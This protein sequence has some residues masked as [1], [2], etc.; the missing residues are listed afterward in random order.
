[1]DATLPYE[2]PAHLEEIV[3][4][5]SRGTA[6]GEPVPLAQWGAAEIGR[7]GIG[8][9]SDLV[10]RLGPVAAAAA[11]TAAT[12]AP[13][14]LLNGRRVEDT[15]Q[16]SA[17]PAE[18]IARVEVLAASVAVRYGEAPNRPVMNF[19][20]KPRFR[21]NTGSGSLGTAPSGGGR[22]REASL[23]TFLLAGERRINL[24]VA[25]SDAAITYGPQDVINSISDR[26]ILA[27][28]SENGSLNLTAASDI[29]G[30]AFTTFGATF[31]VRREVEPLRGQANP[32]ARRLSEEA[33]LHLG[34]T[35]AKQ[36]GR[37]RLSLT[38]E[39]DR[40]ASK[41]RQVGIDTGA[42]WDKANTSSLSVAFVG[43]GPLGDL[44]DGGATGSLALN[45]RRDRF[46][47]G[48]S[49]D[50]AGPEANDDRQWS[51]R[52][53]LTLPLRQGGASK[54]GALTQTLSLTLAGAA[55]SQMVWSG[56][57]DTS[58][59][60]V[61]GLQ[62]DLSLA[63]E[64]HRTPRNVREGAIIIRPATTVFDHRRDELAVVTLVNGG[65]PLLGD[66]VRTRRMAARLFW[67]PSSKLP[68]NAGA[69]ITD[70]RENNGRIAISSSSPLLE[71]AYPERFL[72]GVD[73]G[74]L[75]LDTRPVAVRYSHYR[76]IELSMLAN[77]TIGEG[78]D[79]G[80]YMASLIVLRRLES[81]IALARG[82]TVAGPA[83]GL[84]P[85][86]NGNTSVVF[87]GSVAKASTG[88]D[89]N[90]LWTGRASSPGEIAEQSDRRSASLGMTAEIFT[91]LTGLFP[92]S[93]FV[94][95]SKLSLSLS[96]IYLKRPR[97]DLGSSGISDVEQIVAL[98]LRPGTVLL[99]F[100]KR[101]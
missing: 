90:L 41:T 97:L 75:M 47:T 80:I 99:R 66:A 85:A 78:A 65:N 94:R 93:D 30:F 20:L 82:V 53:G 14:L 73:G 88:V 84:G 55:G 63:M 38:T 67:R 8:S 87:S 52:L 98:G 77:G 9:V 86:G 27:P 68:V 24:A 51:G 29:Y 58:W 12:A 34:L 72:R 28:K 46:D 48:S 56:T 50:V 45:A 35:A 57:S 32:R 100:E 3:V 26:T 22:S 64:R 16:I 43:A 36:V 10:R 1:L 17:I 6:I 23:G 101:F 49:A 11:G 83:A 74:L 81:R 91:G 7:Y 61:P 42:A 60:P 5:A 44:L 92:R 79:A 95:N 31:D 21:A 96:G 15:A 18:A 33:R 40:T 37:W 59:S 62:A 54:S 89:L 19:V 25:A 13:L 76:E 2:S 70:F 39:F 71:Q 4:V 69:Q